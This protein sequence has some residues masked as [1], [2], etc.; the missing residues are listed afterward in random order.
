MIARLTGTFEDFGPDWA[1]ID[2]GG[3][4][5]LVHCSARTLDAL[6]VR[7]D[8][9][10]VHTELQVSENDM[11][12]VGFAS[13]DERVWF[14]LLTGVQGV[15]SKMALAVLSAL[16]VADLQRACAGG[17]VAMVSRAQGVGTK[18]ASRIVNEL[19]D[20]A[21]ALPTAAGAALATAPA[22]SASQDA[23]SALQNLGFKPGVA[24]EAVARAL[25]ELGEG[26]ALGDLVRVG[27]KRAT[28]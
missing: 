7:G 4:G 16:S 1:V 23:V 21:G 2:V 26:A 19:K 12:L 28:G 5:Y 9:V 25:E 14:R 10:T 13:A 17:D 8:R 24:V 20:K 3:V 22:G 18:I 6:G 27:L 15:G 11:R